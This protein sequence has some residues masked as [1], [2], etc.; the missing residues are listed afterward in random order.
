[1]DVNKMVY[2]LIEWM[3]KDPHQINTL[4]VGSTDIGARRS[5]EAF[6]KAN[7]L[8]EPADFEGVVFPSYE[9]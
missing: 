9:Y 4:G 8:E 2:G 3:S 1:M 7:G 5:L 6:A